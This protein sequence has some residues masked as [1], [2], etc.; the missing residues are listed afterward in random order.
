MAAGLGGVGSEGGVGTIIK[1]GGIAATAAALVGI[2]VGIGYY[3]F[4][5]STRNRAPHMTLYNDCTGNNYGPQGEIEVFC[6]NNKAYSIR[7]DQN[8]NLA[9][10]DSVVLEITRKPFLVPKQK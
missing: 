5:G 3:F 2:G 1:Y 4:S 8:G 7:F 6:V 10:L 9:G